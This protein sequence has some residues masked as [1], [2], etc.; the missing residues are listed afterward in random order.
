[1]WGA[2][3]EKVLPATVAGSAVGATWWSLAVD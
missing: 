2:A 3:A 1:M